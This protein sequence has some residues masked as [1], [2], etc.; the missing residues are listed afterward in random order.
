MKIVTTLFPAF[1]WLP[2]PSLSAP[3]SSAE[4]PGWERSWLRISPGGAEPAGSSLP[5]LSSW[6]RGAAPGAAPAGTPLPALPQPHTQP[7]SL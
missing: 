7:C 2:L 1:L 6:Q 3:P 4:R 5:A